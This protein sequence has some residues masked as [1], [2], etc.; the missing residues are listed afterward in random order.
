MY[1]LL[2]CIAILCIL[3]GII[4]ESSVYNMSVC[5]FEHGY[6][7]I[8][9]DQE[10]TSTRVSLYVYS[11]NEVL[12]LSLSLPLSL[13]SSSLDWLQRTV[14]TSSCRPWR[15]R[16]L[17]LQPPPSPTPWT[18]FEPEYRYKLT[19]NLLQFILLVI[20]FTDSKMVLKEV[21]MLSNTALFGKN[22]NIVKLLSQFK[23]T[24]LNI[25]SYSFDGK[26]E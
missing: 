25:I 15:D 5:R 9:M 11:N 18:W 20:R 12:S 13:Q 21:I 4:V 17:Q 14:H 7:T 26:A 23:M 22:S 10:G 19:H 6:T 8:C 3:Y 24:F 2:Y 16:W 1:S